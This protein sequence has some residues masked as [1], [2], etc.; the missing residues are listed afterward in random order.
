MEM[1]PTERWL[2]TVGKV[3][4]LQGHRI[5]IFHF[6]VMKCLWI[7]RGAR[8]D[9][10]TAISYRCT[11]IKKTDIEYWKNLMRVLC[12]TN[13]EINDERII[14]ANNIHEMQTYVD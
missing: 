14:S 2:F 8:M 4:E 10:A 1:L 6:V 11:R 5:T 3:S 13:K 9:C 7:V 12:S